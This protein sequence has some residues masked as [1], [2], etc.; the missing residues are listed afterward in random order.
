MLGARSADETLDLTG[1]P[2][3]LNSS[4]VIIT[5]ELMEP[6]EILDVVVDDGE[7]IENVPTTLAQEGHSVA[8]RR[9]R[10]EGWLLRVI[11]GDDL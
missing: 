5:L 1:V 3:P 11:R 6:G 7:A 10:G 2:C 8:S 4:R 9:K